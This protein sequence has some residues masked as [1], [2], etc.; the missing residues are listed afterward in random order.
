MKMR[1]MLKAAFLLAQAL[2][3]SGS[4]QADSLKE[5][6]DA[7][8]QGREEL[9]PTE[10]SGKQR[11]KCREK[12]KEPPQI[13]PKRTKL[14]HLYAFNTSITGGTSVLRGEDVPFNNGTGV[15]PPTPVVK[16]KGIHQLNITDFIIIENGDYLVTFY[17]Y[18][19]PTSSKLVSGVQLFVNTIPTGPSSILFNPGDT[20]AFS[21]IIRI[22]GASQSHPALIEVKAIVLSSGKLVLESAFPGGID[23]T[24]EIIKLSEH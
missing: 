19:N 21:Q 6:S 15:F 12:P 5:V 10:F 22:S 24:L 14:E 11:Q 1:F 20:L 13:E 7:D 8:Q 23:A 9:S 4:L 2:I 3:L 16:G 18:T 17:G